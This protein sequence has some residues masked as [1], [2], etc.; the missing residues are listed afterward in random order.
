[1]QFNPVSNQLVSCSLSELT[2]WS[3]EQKNLQKVKSGGRINCCSWTRDGQYLAIGFSS[4]YASIRNKNGEEYVRIDRPGVSPIWSLS[5]GPPRDEQNGDIL[6]LAE[7]NGTISFYSQTGRQIGRERTI[8]FIPLK[9]MFFPDGQYLLIVGSNNKCLLM[10]ND[11]F[12]LKQIG[13]EQD[14]WIWSCC[15]DLTSTNIAIGTQNGTIIYSKLLWNIVHGLYGERYAYRENMTDVIIQNLHT[16]QKVRIKCKDL[17]KRIA[18]YRDKLAVQLSERVII[19]ELSGNDGMHYRSHEK[20]GQSLDCNLLVVTSKHLV[21]CL[22]NILQSLSFTGIIERQWILDN[23]ITY[24][25]VIGGP[26]GKECLLIGLKNG[27]VIK[28]YLDNPFPSIITK[29]DGPISCLDTS[30]LKDKLSIVSENGTLTIINMY[31]DDDDDD[32]KNIIK[33]NNVISVS[34]NRSFEDMFC[35]STNNSL[36]IKVGNFTEFKQKFCG[37]VVGFNGTKVYC[38]NGTNITTLDISL[39][40]TMYQYLDIN[41]YKSAYKIACLGVADNDWLSLG[42]SALDK[43][44]LTIAKDAFGR[45]KKLNYIEVICE[46]E[47]KLESGEWGKEAC[48]AIAS[49][50]MGKLRAAAKLYQKAGLQQYALDMYS[51]LRMFD[52]AQEFIT[53]GNTNDRT[54]LLRRRAEWAMSLGEPR[55]ASEMFLSAGDIQRA[56]NII[57]E[58]GWIDMLIKIGRQIDKA[59]RNYLT[60]IGKKLRQ[61]G[62]THG[63][64]EIFTRLGDDK[65]VADVLVD[66]K[67]WPDAFELAE[68]NEKLKSIIY[69]PYARWLVETGRF[70]EAQEAFKMAGQPEESIIVLN[71]LANN[72]I[73]E[74]RYKDASYFYWLLSQLSLEL[75]K[76]F[77]D[78]KLLFNQ[79]SDKADIYYV[80]HEIFLYQE[81]PFTS[82][83]PEALFSM[84]RYLINKLQGDKL[85]DGISKVQ[86]IYTL[87]KQAKIL[88]AYKLNMQ[89]LER[90]RD[91]KIP[92]Y[93]QS[94]IEILTLGARSYQYSDPEELLPLC[95][96]CSTFNSLLPSNNSSNSCIQCGLKFQYSFLHFEILPLVEFQLDDGIDNNEALRLIHEPIKNDNCLVENQLT[97]GSEE[98]DLFTA[99]MI[100]YDDK[101]NDS[102]VKVGRGVLKSIDPTSVIIVKWPVPFKTRYY[103]NL[104]PDVQVTFCKSCL[105]VN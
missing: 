39:T 26:I 85:I 55:A 92:Y 96:R 94:Q 61:L 16:N 50:S 91:M 80:Y 10:T 84:S 45:L 99:K 90:L 62:A 38:I 93:Q 72:A 71:T 100:K 44:E 4:G 19:Y 103:K 2:I 97:I 23:S 101:I 37:F 77:D 78:I 83:Q 48:M 11:G 41:D 81:E 32:E 68:R 1:M 15:V 35:F 40:S 53:S 102:I 73:I 60:L 95:Y 79:Y 66:A 58:Y 64:A 27:Q 69:G 30:S 28:I 29:T 34:F 63:A 18:V 74:K 7:W 76:N 6:V 5:W 59:E 33:Y 8:D 98:D 89:L 87:I 31:N 49:A 20:L 42:L 51:D 36:S 88:G 105:R 21:L 75:N 43:L 82:L 47:D 52:S 25:K 12:K 9:I 22:D 86:I 24:I 104:L 56:I 14:T 65:D 46:I 57:S 3:T 13:D 54:I 70:S 67:A 17:I